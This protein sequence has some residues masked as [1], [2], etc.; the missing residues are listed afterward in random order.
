MA[1]QAASTAGTRARRA[2]ARALGWSLA[3]IV[4]GAMVAPLGGYVYVAVAPEAVADEQPAWDDNPRADTWG[5]AREGASGTTAASGPYTTNSLIA[6]GG[7]NWR[8]LRNGPV[9]TFTPWL[10]ALS[11]LAL[12]LLYLTAGPH[13]IE[14]PLSGRKVKRWAGWERTMHWF[15]AVTFII[16]AITGL[17]LL[18]GRAVLIPVLGHEGFAAWAVAAKW[19]HNVVGP[20]FTVGILLMLLTWARNNLFNRTDVQ[21]F[22]K[23]GGIFTGQHVSAGK[24]NGGE[25]AWYWFVV[26]IGGGFVCTTGLI[27]DFPNFGQ[28][29]ETMQLASL[30]HAVLA[31]LW[32]AIAFGHIYLGVVGAKGAL[33]GM[34]TGYVSEEWAREHHDLWLE[35]VRRSGEPV[36]GSESPSGGDGPATPD[37]A[38]PVP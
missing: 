3:L 10:M 31:I 2:H 9:A 28:S 12:G 22:R 24:L 17:S 13:R 32:I 7:E 4:I 16:L 14:G 8:N 20:F 18:F 37:P 11:L 15:V 27:L 29:R 25:K 30:I 35:E 36:A 19:L 21:W 26:I 5:D 34:T 1:R 6:N 38:R 23:G 33:E